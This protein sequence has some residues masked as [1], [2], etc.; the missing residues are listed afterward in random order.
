[1]EAVSSSSLG[2][3][4][5]L[6]RNEEAGSSWLFWV[7]DPVRIYAGARSDFFYELLDSWSLSRR[8]VCPRAVGIAFDRL[9]VL[10][11]VDGPPSIVSSSF[12]LAHNVLAPALR[13]KDERSK[14]RLARFCVIGLGVIA[15][16]V[17]LYADGIYNLV[18]T[19]SAF[20]TAGVL[21]ITLAALYLPVGG[22]RAASAAL[23]VGLVATP[24]FEYQ[25][26]V[27]A[28]F[29]SSLLAATLA[30][31]SF[32]WTRRPLTFKSR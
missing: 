6:S 4:S 8:A 5:Q 20:G 7:R 27:E 14:L 30:Y 23:L 25:L 26:E 10:F 19:A 18:E 12:L 1:M 21:V 24:F 29:L 15:L 28:P 31:L 17:A 11:A 16:V 2:E 32:S 9:R 13:V 3:E 22:G